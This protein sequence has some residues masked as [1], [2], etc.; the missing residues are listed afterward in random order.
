[1]CIRDRSNV[2]KLLIL[3]F[4]TSSFFL[5]G[6]DPHYYFPHQVGN[7]WQYI[8]DSGVLSSIEFLRDS[9]DSYKNHYIF[10]G[11]TFFIDSYWKWKINSSGDSIIETPFFRNELLYR[12][13]METGDIWRVAPN[14][15]I[16]RVDNKY[17][18]NWGGERIAVDISYWPPDSTFFHWVWQETYVYGIGQ[19]W[20]GNEVMYKNLIG[21]IIN[22]DTLGIIIG[23]ENDKISEYKTFQLSQNYPNPFNPLTTIEYQIATKVFINLTIYDILG[24]EITVLVNEEKRPG[25]YTVQF[26]GK[27]L[28]SGIYYYK[29]QAG[30]NTIIKAMVLLK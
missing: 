1:M 17:S 4:V 15:I 16:A 6:Q 29:L 25:K 22:G 2:M 7:L 26:N 20:Y 19:I 27:N 24:R 30:D 28:A 12:F 5:H 9:I 14:W 8:D 13:P 3:I 21:C 18:V 11:D 23:V 10:Q